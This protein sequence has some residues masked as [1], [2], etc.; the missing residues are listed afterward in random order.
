MGYRLITPLLKHNEKWARCVQTMIS[1]RRTKA[2]SVADV[3]HRMSRLFEE[4]LLEKDSFENNVTEVHMRD[5][6]TPLSCSRRLSHSLETHGG[7][8]SEARASAA[9]DDSE[10]AKP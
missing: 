10:G 8:W 3:D 9:G 2:G 7:T 4:L 5:S 6:L 1:S